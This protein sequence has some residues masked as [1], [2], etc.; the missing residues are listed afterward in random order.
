M[1]V[2]LFIGDSITRQTYLSFVARISLRYI[3]DMVLKVSWG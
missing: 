3:D 2:V 1:P